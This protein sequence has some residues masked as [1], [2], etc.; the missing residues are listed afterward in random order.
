MLKRDELAD[1]KSCLSRAL[2]DERVFVLLARDKAA[3]AAIRAWVELRVALGKN[4]RDDGQIVEAL[5]CAAKMEYASGDGCLPANALPGPPQA[6]GKRAFKFE[7]EYYKPSGKFY[8]NATVVWTVRTAAGGNCPYMADA[9]AK[10]RALRDTG[11]PDSLPGLSGEGWDGPIRLTCQDGF[12]VML[13][14]RL[15]DANA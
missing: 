12:P 4:Q 7:I 3:P 14:D 8:T 9:L 10:L 2:P 6:D 15:G 1:P 11:G 13:L 5:D